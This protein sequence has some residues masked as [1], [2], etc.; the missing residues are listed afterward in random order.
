MRMGVIFGVDGVLVPVDCRVL[1]RA[2]LIFHG[3]V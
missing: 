1:L 2:L 3:Y